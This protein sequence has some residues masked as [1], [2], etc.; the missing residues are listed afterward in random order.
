MPRPSLHRALKIALVGS[1]VAGAAPA[2][3][4]SVWDS[5]PL[6]KSTWNV[7]SGF[8]MSDNVAR[9]P[10]GPS[11]TTFTI[12]ATGG[13][14]KDEGRLFAN[15]RGSVWFEE[16]LENTFD[17]E[18]L[19]S[20]AAALRYDFVPERLSWSLDNTYGQT[21]SDTFQAASPGNRSNA[22]FFST[23]PDV[24]WPFGQVAGIRLGGRY[25]LSSFED[26]AQLDEERLR[27]NVGLFRR[28]SPTTTGSING[29]LA[30]TSF[31]GGSVTVGP[32]QTADGYDI[33]EAFARLETR[34]A[35]YTLSIDGGITQVEQRGIQEEMPLVRGNFYRRLTPSLDL[36]LSGGQEYRSAGDILQEAIA[37]VRFVNNQV[38]FIPPGVDP[39]F[40]Y[41]VIQDLNNRSQ[42]VKYQFV[43]ASLDFTRPRTAFNIG[44]STGQERFQFSGQN[45]DRDVMDASVSLSR[46]L[47]PNLT[48][49]IG[50]N[51]YDRQ[52]VNLDG[53]DENLG[54]R[55]QVSWQYNSQIAFNFGYRYD[56]RD[57]DGSGFSYTE[58]AVF[59][60]IN[61][62]RAK[63]SLFAT[64]TGETMPGTLA[65]TSTAPRSTIPAG[66]AP[67][68][69]A[70]RTG[71]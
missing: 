24:T 56:E 15:V 53:G 43:R 60:G 26:D 48:A 64:P 70:P 7:F 30:E 22:N 10:D 2:H 14:F 45:L 49:T 42:P 31:K 44:G 39:S 62:G 47:R 13:F 21:T 18:L 61:Y 54:G 28:F 37:G 58:N 63:P 4:Q 20:L 1:V 17:S 51:Y 38:V 41:N 19:G 12:G 25:E 40:V 69:V 16:Y 50:L 57:S 35:R 52:F 33:R 68:P 3:A 6:P 46:R 8:T 36:N 5:F 23:G 65:P 67:T 29:S 34:R 32:G 59:V 27:G 9:I 66:G 71:P 55:L 11:D